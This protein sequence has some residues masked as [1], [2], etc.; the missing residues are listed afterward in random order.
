MGKKDT[1]GAKG[2]DQ[3]VWRFS[4]PFDAI[5][6]VVDTVNHRTS[7]DT[8][9]HIADPSRPAA[10]LSNSDCAC[11]AVIG[12]RSRTTLNSAISNTKH[13]PQI[14]IIAI[15]IRMTSFLC[16]GQQLRKTTLPLRAS[17]YTSLGHPRHSREPRPSHLS[18]MVI[19]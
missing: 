19:T 7:S 16:S 4:N 12:N 17:H 3:W 5:R 8:L 13:A 6:P 15:K 11:R 2:S 9:A 1:P 10:R 14:M 18:V